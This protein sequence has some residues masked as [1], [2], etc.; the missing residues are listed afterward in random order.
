MSGFRITF[1]RE[2]GPSCTFTV[3]RAVNLPRTDYVLNGLDY[4]VRK[5]FRRT[6]WTVQLDKTTLTRTLTTTTG[7]PLGRVIATPL[8][9]ARTLDPSKLQRVAQEQEA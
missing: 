3:P 2:G 5:A 6:M 9:E 4:R 7:E 1:E 8:A